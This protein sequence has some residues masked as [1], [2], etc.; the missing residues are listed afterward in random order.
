ML[1]ILLA[2]W[3]SVITSSALSRTETD[4]NGIVSFAWSP[5]SESDLAGYR[6]YIGAT[7]YVG[8][9]VFILNAGQTSFSLNFPPGYYAWLT[10]F[11]VAGIESEPTAALRPPVGVLN[12]IFQESPDLVTWTTR[13]TSEIFCGLIPSASYLESRL[14]ITKDH[15]EVVVLG[16]HVYYP[17]DPADAPKR[18]FR[19]FV[20]EP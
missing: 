5:N 18:F 9:E 19:S 11:N 7:P 4:P 3:F 20:A 6:F 8:E 14:N 13:S 17:I 1:K 2:I 16:R 12:L 10:A 15:V